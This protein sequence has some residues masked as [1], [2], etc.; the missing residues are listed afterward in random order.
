[1]KARILQALVLIAL[2]LGGT[3]EAAT[4][5]RMGTLAPKGSSWHQLLEEM[6]YRWKEATGGEVRL[7]IY[8]GGVVGGE[9]D[10]IRKMRIGQLQ[11]AAI[12]NA[13]LAEVER[14]AYGLMVP[15]MFE[16]YEEWD[17]VRNQI[18]RDLEAQ[19]EAKEFRV[20][21]W[22]DVGWVYFFT[23][24]PLQT[25]DQLRQRRLGASP[26]E[27]ATVD[28]MK[29]AGLNPV[30][31][32][33]AD[34]ATGLQTGLIDTIYI[35]LIFAQGSQLYRDARNMTDLRWVPLQGALVIHESGFQ[36]IPPQ[37][38]PQVLQIAREIGERLRL[39]TRQQEQEA[40]DTM[41]Q[42]GLQVWPV[43]GETLEKWRELAIEAYP[44]IRE[45][46]VSPEIFD[47]VQRLRDQFRAGQSSA[48]KTRN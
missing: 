6:G 45:Q 24:T 22:S 1:M 36:E 35:P 23:K 7:T 12:S 16:S 14:S 30:P 46:L 31:I 47:K 40:L 8:A 3:L 15:M 34:T 17:F 48:S 37:H 27:T 42:R 20:L 44:R 4:K 43:D 10:M 9:E 32:T 2:T 38:R 41:K 11:A 33:I 18:N 21:T 28:I 13:G 5:I 25:P 29:W 19:L 26:T 39:Q